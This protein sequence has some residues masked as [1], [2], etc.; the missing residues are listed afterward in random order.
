MALSDLYSKD[1]LASIEFKKNILGYIEDAK[2]L[3]KGSTLYGFPVDINNE[4]HII[5]VL[6]LMLM[7]YNKFHE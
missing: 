5:A 4:D 1:Y 3:C 7:G 2:E 6:Y